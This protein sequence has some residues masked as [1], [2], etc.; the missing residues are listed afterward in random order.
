M[1]F[2]G[3]YNFNYYK[4]DTL[5]FKIY[6]K[7]TNG[8][9]FDLTGY[10]VDFNIAENRG[11][12]QNEQINAYSNIPVDGTYVSCAII[13]ADGNL[14]SAGTNYV[15]DIEIKK[16]SG[17]P[18]PL[19]YTLLTGNITVTE[20]VTNIPEEVITAPEAPSDLLVAEIAPGT[21]GA[22]WSAPTGGD[23]PTGYRIY[24]KAP[25]A[26]VV[27]YIEIDT[28]TGT[29][30]S[31]STVFGFPLAS[32][33]QYFVKVTSFNTAGESTGFVEGSVTIA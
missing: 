13:P 11:V 10:T 7:N 17:S 21:I 32:G 19:V 27:D 26:G 9:A 2:P 14:M 1:A 31:A 4:G 30:Y 5:E 16:T 25:T 22:Q 29:T 23:A 28:V 20:Q 12:A 8:T 24:G 6:P 3:T 18:Y 15:Y 33:V